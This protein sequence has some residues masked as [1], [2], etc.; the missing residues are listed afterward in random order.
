[1]QMTKHAANKLT[2]I[3]WSPIRNPIKQPQQLI[4]IVSRN[5]K[6]DW[7]HGNYAIATLLPWNWEKPIKGSAEEFL[8]KLVEI[9]DHKLN[10]FN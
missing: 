4:R 9:S 3:C 10:I 7:L 8:F 5:V 2:F 6:Y 1:M